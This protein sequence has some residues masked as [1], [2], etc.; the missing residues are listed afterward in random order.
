MARLKKKQKTGSESQLSGLSDSE[1]FLRRACDARQHR[2]DWWLPGAIL[3]N[4]VV[5]LEGK[6]GT[7]KTPTLAAIA[8]SITGGP[9]IPG[10]NGPRDGCVLWSSGEEDWEMFVTPRLEAMGC[11]LDRVFNPAIPSESGGLRK[12]TL[13][14]DLELLERMIAA[15]GV[16]AI[17][18][19]P[20]LSMV[21]PNIEMTKTQPARQFMEHLVDI[22]ARLKC[23]VVAT[24]H[25][26]K[27]R[28]GD[29]KDKGQ[30]SVEIGNA[31]R[32]VLRCDE[33]PSI[34]DH[35]VLS[36]VVCNLCRRPPARVFG[37]EDIKRDFKP[38]V[39]VPSSDLTLEDILSSGDDAAKR[40]EQA[41]CDLMLYELI[42]GGSIAQGDILKEASAAGIKP[43]VLRQCKV[44]LRIESDRK[45]HARSGWWEWTAPLS[46]WP[47]ELIDRSAKK[48]AATVPITARILPKTGGKMRAETLKNTQGAQDARESV[49]VPS[50]DQDVEVEN[51]EA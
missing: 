36:T 2:L 39:W 47:P 29:L 35:F 6:K 10:W 22:A 50:F 15:R 13:P 44:R 41:D 27:G 26:T 48:R 7:G 21:P 34:L 19:D 23:L 18:L 5:T 37:F 24:R 1:L 32:S 49:P 33:H 43:Y 28:Q 14:R 30:G 51:G 38:M 12:M 16:K 31:S 20:L 4:T 25:L 42:G 45:S 3:G 11:N 17:M 8:T 46:G 40:D 9:A